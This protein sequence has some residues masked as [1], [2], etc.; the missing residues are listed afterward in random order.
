MSAPNEILDE[1][2]SF[3]QHRLP[4]LP[5]GSYQVTLSQRLLDQDVSIN[6]EPIS[7]TYTFAVVGDRFHLQTP[8]QTV[9]SV[10]PEDQASGEFS[11]VLPHVVMT[12]QTL[13]WSRYPTLEPP[14]PEPPPGHDTEDDVP[15][16]LAVLLFDEDDLALHPTLTL[17]PESQTV[18]DLF[19]PKLHKPSTLGP[20]YSYFYNA[21]NTDLDVGDTLVTQINTIDVPLR[22]FWQTCP[23][24]S[25]LKLLAHLRE[26]SLEN[27][28][29]GTGAAEIGEPIGRFS[30]V[31]GNR[32]PQ[33][34]KKAYAYL[35]SL[36]ELQ[37]F[38]PQSDGT[39][40][41]PNPFDPNL[42]IRLAVLNSWTFFSTGESATFVKQLLELNGRVAESAKDAAD[43]TL[44]LPYTGSNTVVKNALRMSY[45][46]LNHKLRSGGQTVSWYRG[47]LVPYPIPNP[48][49]RFPIAS[50]DQAT[51][52][53]PTTGMFDSSYGAAWTLGRQLA[54]QD[55]GFSTALYEWKKGLTEDVVNS[56]ENKIL[57]ERLRPLLASD[58]NPAIFLKM[59]RITPAQALVH[60]LIF[61]LHPERSHPE[62]PQPRTLPET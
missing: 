15:T 19:P 56:I 16:W 30:I 7:R 33:T 25:D 46:P 17:G 59:K 51:R 34:Q 4:G 47:P 6:N 41:D 12:N 24:L 2:V 61:S 5:D 10:F 54:L 43:T 55:K 29:T 8:T 35:V 36:E 28:P 31:F 44:T 60:K 58:S 20:N 22:L 21:D 37:P 40:P 11:A 62:T 1:L 52:F 32:L 39:P 27:K 18:G 23:S 49:I 38:L 48:R 9:F 3:I 53:D 42:C 26:V 13:P 45:V 57:E 14:V 50:P